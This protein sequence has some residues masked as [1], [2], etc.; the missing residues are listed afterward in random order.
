MRTARRAACATW[1]AALL[2]CPAAATGATVVVDTHCDKY[3]CRETLVYSAVRGERNDVTVAQ[4]GDLVTIRDTA[5]MEPGSACEA[6]DAVSARCAFALPSYSRSASFKLGD[7]DDRLDARAL[8]MGVAL[9][10][11]AGDDRLVG[12]EAV[13]ARFVGGRGGDELTGGPFPDRF[14][15]NRRDGRDTMAGGGPPPLLNAGYY[16]GYDEVAYGRSRAVR[17]EL[18]GRPNDGARGEHDNL[19]SIEGVWTGGGSD[20]IIGSPSDEF[21]YGGAGPDLLRGRGGADRLVGGDRVV[22]GR[23][24]PEGS[25]D[26]LEG[27]AGPDVL[28]GRG[29]RDL[30]TGGGG[31]DQLDGGRGQDRIRARDP[32]RD[33]VLCG[34]G[35]DRLQASAADVLMRGCERQRGAVSSA[36][37]LV[38][39]RFGLAGVSLIVGCPVAAREDC[40]GTLTLSVPGRPQAMSTYSAE[41]GTAVDVFLPLSPDVDNAG[42]LSGALASTANDSARFGELPD[43][44]TDSFR[45]ALGVPG[46]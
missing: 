2:A 39:W 9:L 14:E 4:E 22:A 1:V 38:N 35:F 41:P 46:L 20:V 19:L 36:E 43:W 7:H 8:A 23:D 12:P 16:P 37:A 25:P 5:G 6:L 13:G 45:D 11:G 17:V 40:E 18:D 33:W 24:I 32:D 29:G 28:D 3:G 31:R 30:L 34:R 15:S 44:P 27:G 26:R 21:M 42:Q 10:G